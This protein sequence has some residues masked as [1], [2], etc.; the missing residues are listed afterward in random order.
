ME[1]VL[2]FFISAAKIGSADLVSP[3]ALWHVKSTLDKYRLWSNYGGINSN[4]QSK[5]QKSLRI[6]PWS[7]HYSSPQAVPNACHWYNKT[8]VS[9]A[10]EKGKKHKRILESIILFWWHISFHPL[11]VLCL[12]IW[13]HWKRQKWNAEYHLCSILSPSAHHQLPPSSLAAIKLALVP[14]A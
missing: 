7:T 11:F 9:W 10:G 8:E 4:N 5:F 1:Q 13:E 2:H 14:L 12:H 3:L 6:F